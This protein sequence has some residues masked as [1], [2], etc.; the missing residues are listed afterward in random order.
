MPIRTVIF[1][2]YG[3]L[4]DVNGAARLAAAEPEFPQL[5]QAWP[6]LAADWRAKQLEYSWLRAITG[7]HADFWQVTQDGLDWALEAQGLEDPALRARLLALY[8]DLPAYPEALSCLQSLRGRGLRCGILSNGSTEMLQAACDRAGLSPL[9]EALLSVDA[10]G[11]FKPAAPVYDLVGQYFGT[12]KA[13]VAFVSSNGW[14]AG[15][16]AAYG[17]RTFWVNR[18]KAPMDR[19]PGR[20][21]ITVE[22]LSYVPHHL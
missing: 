22:D 15:C 21:E 14:D 13:E 12:S 6:K 3:T 10:V 8:H 5:A 19:L 18:V 2:A 1:D 4:L 11:V 7:D 20:P 16:A 17:F 9:L